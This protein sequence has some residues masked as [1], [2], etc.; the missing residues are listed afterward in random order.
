MP[1]PELRSHIPEL[2][3]NKEYLILCAAGVRAA[4]ATLLLR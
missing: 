3:K 4:A 2:D 1:L